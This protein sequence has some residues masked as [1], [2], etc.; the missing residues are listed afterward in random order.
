MMYYDL[1]PEVPG[2]IG[3]YSN[4]DLLQYPVAGGQLQY[5]FHGWLGDCLVTSTPL[6]LITM[7]AGK[8]LAGLSVT[9]CSLAT[10]VVS[11]S[12]EFEELH[13]GLKLPEFAWL[14]VGGEVGVDDFALSRGLYLV[15][16]ERALAVLRRHGLDH[17][18]VAE[19]NLG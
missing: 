8:E 10:A 11:V 13:P 5:T 1:D 6:F 16:S 15:V 4:L 7:E 9:G 3:N 17:A 12:E 2:E 14:K 18:D 19:R